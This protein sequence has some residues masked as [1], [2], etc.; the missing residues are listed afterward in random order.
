MYSGYFKAF[1][2]IISQALLLLLP[3]QHENVN[4]K[5]FGQIALNFRRILTVYKHLLH[6]ARSGLQRIIIYVHAI[7]ASGRSRNDGSQLIAYDKIRTSAEP[8]L[9][10][11]Q[12][13]F[14]IV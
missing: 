14:D 9:A 8:N 5:A 12:M 4:N 3:Y 2:Q 10:V 6:A 13:Q 1:Y 7:A 11:F